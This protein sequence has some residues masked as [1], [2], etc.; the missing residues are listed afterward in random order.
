[1]ALTFISPLSIKSLTSCS[2]SSKAPPVRLSSL[3]NKHFSVVCQIDPAKRHHFHVARNERGSANGV[4]GSV[5]IISRFYYV[6]YSKHTSLLHWLEKVGCSN[7]Q[8]KT[9]NAESKNWKNIVSAAL[10][11]AVISFSSGNMPAIADLNKFEAETPGEFGIGSAAQF[12]SADL[13]KAVHVNENFRRANFTS[14][15]MRESDFSGSTFNGAY[16]EKAVAYKA[17]FAGA[18]LSDTLMDRMVLNEAN[19]KDAVLVR[20][21]LTRSDLGGALIEG[22]DFSDAVLDLLQKQA[23][24]KYASGTNP[25]TGVSTRASLG[26]GNS[27]RNAYGSPS[28]PLLSAPPQKLLNRDGFCDQGTGLCDVK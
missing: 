4:I 7:K 5:E 15:D 20:S 18:D 16:M 9:N 8:N 14:A 2:S 21:V 6:L 17:N 27:R 10:A 25:T 24:C 23:L 19:L 13:R 11:A 26:C 3:S 22:A 12:G 28:S 1:M